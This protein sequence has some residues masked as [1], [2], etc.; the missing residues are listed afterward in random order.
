MAEG[1]NVKY[2][3]MNGVRWKNESKNLD[4]TASMPLN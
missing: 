4:S 3:E 1:I 2:R